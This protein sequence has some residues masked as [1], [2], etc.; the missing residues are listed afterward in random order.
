MDKETAREIAKDA[1]QRLAKRLGEN[2]TFPFD[3]IWEYAKTDVPP[4]LKP[5][6]ANELINEG[7]LERTGAVVNASSPGRA[8]NRGPEYRLGPRF[9]K[10]PST[11]RG[12]V[13]TAGAV[14][15]LE[16][17]MADAG[18][19]ITSAELANLYLA[20][21]SSPL[22]ILAGISGTGKSKIPRVFAKLMTA[23]FSFIPVKPQW[24]D[25]SDLF[26]YSPTLNPQQFIEGTLTKTLRAASKQPETLSIVLLDEMNLA[27]VEHYFSDFL[28]VI[29]TR[30]RVKN[31]ILTDPL[32]LDLPAPDKHDQYSDL[33]NL[34]LPSNV[35]IIGTANMDETTRLFSPKVL[36][37]AFS[38]E[39]D[40]PALTTFA[41]ATRRDYDPSG[42]HA[43]MVN[44]LDS[45]NP[46]SVDEV[47]SDSETLFEGIG[48]L[49]EEVREILRP[50]GISFGFRP[51]NDI[52]IYMYHWQK[53][54][55]ASVL[56]PTA[57]MDWCFL[58]K[59][60]PK[61]SGT[62]EALREAL[63]ALLTWLNTNETAGNT[64]PLSVTPLQS[65]PWRRSAD[66]LQRMINRLEVEGA[67][68]FW[69]T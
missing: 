66:K 27:A 7:Y 49:L 46:V 56:S 61:L 24:S 34:G 8:G 5:A 50:S 68:T 60:L 41:V 58:Q 21:L 63:E 55:L 69:G 32:P 13:T 40:E 39:F 22:I 1:V 20:L 48:T 3:V 2:A 57:A 14:R 54:D 65:R 64:N 31:A 35:R 23:E 53:Q 43:L 52:C 18:I 4:K 44:L 28:S 45:S 25:N 33:R 36:D 12:K 9:R 62:G 51:R 42:F 59:I 37:R 16:A 10:Q 17:A 6:R 47:F 15:S 38:I 30:R 29:E 26:G 67:T 19:V 11:R